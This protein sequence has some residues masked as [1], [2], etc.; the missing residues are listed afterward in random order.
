VQQSVQPVG[1]Q[2]SPEQESPQPRYYDARKSRRGFVI[3]LITVVVLGAAAIVV[4]RSD[5]F[6]SETPQVRG[7]TVG[8]AD[9]DTPPGETDA[10]VADVGSTGDYGFD[11]LGM[12]GDSITAGSLAEL[13]YVLK[14]HGVEEA[15]IDGV[16]SRRIE[17]G[18]GKSEPLN[19]VSTL[20]GLL[21]DG[22][23]PDAWVIALGTN[24]VGQYGDEVEYARL[25]DTIVDMLPADVPLVWVDVYRPQYLQDTEA[26]NRI[27]RDRLEE[28]GHA[29]VA[30]WYDIASR[31]D[32]Q[33]LQ[34]DQIHPNEDGRAAFA[35]LVAAALATLTA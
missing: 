26:F 23:E 22:L 1:Q 3:A 7:A 10:D 30:S 9:L 6:T 12:V 31:P 20:Y 13:Q 14:A 33:V 24:D 27:V 28:R 34:D 4:L 5:R 16:P 19:G 21:A 29:A 11:T 15:T 2:S 25:V 18:N 32:Q 35:G 8:L 17:L